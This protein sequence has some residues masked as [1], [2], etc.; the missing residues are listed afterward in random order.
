M[1]EV[2]V[3]GAGASGL[4]AA[5]Y[6]ARRGLRTLVLSQ[7]IGGQAA[8]AS[9]IENYPGIDPIGGRELMERFRA[10]AVS[11]GAEVR[12]SEVMKIEQTGDDF[13]VTAKGGTFHTRA[14]ILTHGLSRRH[15]GIP[16]EEEL[17]GKGVM[18][19]TTC[20]APQYIGKKVAVVGGGNSAMDAALL[21]ASSSPEV[22]LFTENAELRGERV[23]ID[24]V[25]RTSRI[26]VHYS[27]KV[28][29]VRG[30][31]RVTG[32]VV[33]EQDGMKTYGVEGVF[34]EIGFTVKSELVRDLVE[35]DSRR[36]III[37]SENATSV[38]GLFAAGDVTSIE[39][40]QV[41][42]SAGEGARAA[43]TA[44]RYLQARNVVKRA[45]TIDWGATKPPTM[46]ITQH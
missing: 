40:K 27:V 25:F 24:R 4:T 46:N 39:E 23:L 21:L 7:D 2:I 18:Y 26:T 14:V 28:R 31:D 9:V 34:V 22:H 29:E 6:A 17:N 44:Y 5:L 1:Y 35:T 38:P 8:T 19:C 16:G 3:I 41:V 12:L 30:R 37:T 42:I 20:D 45:G 15:M 33:E 43:L 32:L 13:R 11:F 36:Q 10:Q